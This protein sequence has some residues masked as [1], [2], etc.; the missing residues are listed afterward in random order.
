MRCDCSAVSAGRQVADDLQRQRALQSQVGQIGQRARLERLAAREI[1]PGQRRELLLEQV[2][3]A[4]QLLAD[5]AIGAAPPGRRRASR[6]VPR[7]G[8]ATATAGAMD[9][10]AAR[11]RRPPS[12]S[13]SSGPRARA[14]SAPRSRPACPDRRPARRPPPRTLP[15]LPG[16]RGVL[17]MTASG[18]CSSR[19]ARSALRMSAATYR[20][21][22]M[23]VASP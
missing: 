22:F 16:R 3:Q 21:I 8:F 12:R 6:A 13:S 18:P 17:R 4:A 15:R 19:M 1:I 20:F 11:P 2:A 23:S 9:D 14:A 10:R 7:A 5:R